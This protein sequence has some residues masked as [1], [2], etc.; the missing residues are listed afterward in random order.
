MTNWS[1][2][3]LGEIREEIRLEK[4]PVGVVPYIEIGSIDVNSK[5]VIFS[6]KGAV[7]GSIFCPENSILISRVRPTR[8]AVVLVDK[9]YAVSSAFTIVKPKINS[10][11]LFYFLAWNREF[12]EYLGNLQK[13]TSYPSVRE[14]DILDFE[15][16]IPENSFTQQ[17]I[18]KI[19]DS[20]QEAVGVQE[21]IIEKTKELKKS[22]LNEIFNSK[23]KNQNVKLHFKIQNYE[24]LGAVCKLRKEQVLPKVIDK[25]VGLEHLGSGEVKIKNWGKGLEVKSLKNKFYPEDILYGKLRPYLD[26]AAVAD[27]EGVCSTDILVIMCE[28]EKI[29]PHYLIHFIHTPKF[30]NFAIGTTSGTN[31]PRTSWDYLKN[32]KIPLPPLPEQRKIAEILQTIDQKI[33]IEQKKKALYEELFKT[34]LNKIMNQEIDAEKIKI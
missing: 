31:H 28:K 15:I 10:R 30:L 25:Y 26:K 2:K 29:L 4:A 16:A 22:L 32:F 3:K 18:I 5:K 1:T 33:E 12:F 9:K 24:E 11:L 27:F 17:K 19:L 21:K 14:N 7:K 20:V 6:D 34:M 8:G 23:I 13:G